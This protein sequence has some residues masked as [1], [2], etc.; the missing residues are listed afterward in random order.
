[1]FFNLNEIKIF[2]I[3][4]RNTQGLKKKKEKVK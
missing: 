3:K 2:T 1:M 4:I